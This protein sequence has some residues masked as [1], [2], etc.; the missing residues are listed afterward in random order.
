MHIGYETVDPRIY[1]ASKKNVKVNY[2]ETIAPHIDVV[3]FWVSFPQLV[4]PLRRQY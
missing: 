2:L 1:E 3:Y 4:P